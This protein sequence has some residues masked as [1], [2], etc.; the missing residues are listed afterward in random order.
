MSE[1]A[2]T[3][4]DAQFSRSGSLLALVRK[5][6]D[7]GRELAAT[8]QQRSAA[9]DLVP[10]LRSFGTTDI[11][12]ILARIMRGLQ[13]A[14]ALKERIIQSAARLDTNLGPRVPRGRATRA[15]SRP[16][17]QA[18]P[19]TIAPLSSPEQIASAALD[20]VV[21]RQPIGAVIADICRDLGILPNHPL[22]RQLQQAI[23][24]F[25]GNYARLVIDILKRPRLFLAEDQRPTMQ[26]VLL[27]AP[28]CGT[29]P[30]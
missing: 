19:T 30:P 15:A 24:A 11:A 1:A 13:R 29:G 9:T 20:S 14:H 22:W 21:S 26:T 27:P 25:R 6:I 12:R 5:L 16:T 10:I 17:R 18:D 4:P 7:F 3:P 28:A 23:N 8:L 2:T